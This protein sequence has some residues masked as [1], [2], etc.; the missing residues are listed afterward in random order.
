MLKTLSIALL[1]L[2][3]AASAATRTV[4]V[5]IWSGYLT[6][7]VAKDFEKK[8][9]IKVVVSNYSSNEELLAKIQAGAS[10]Y[11][12]VVPSDYMVGV[13]AKQNLI[14]PLDHSKLPHAS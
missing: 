1:L 5:A 2:S 9:G 8:T 13:M 10:G 6:P 7:E 11:D 12:V 3:S 4:H 14:R